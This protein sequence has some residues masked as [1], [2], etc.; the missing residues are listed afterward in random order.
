M[1]DADKQPTAENGFTQKARPVLRVGVVGLMVT[2]GVASW[3]AYDTFVNRIAT[4]LSAV[5]QCCADYR[6]YKEEDSGQRHYWV[7][8]IGDDTKRIRENERETDRAHARIDVLASDAK[9]RPDPFTGTDGRRLEQRVLR[10]E[11]QIDN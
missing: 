10:L 3:T 11:Q 2:I 6:S 4:R 9:A 5:E 7:E 8:R 1:N